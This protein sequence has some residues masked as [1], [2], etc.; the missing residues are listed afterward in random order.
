MRIIGRMDLARRASR[1]G[2]IVPPCAMQGA[3]GAVR[4][5]GHFTRGARRRLVLL[6]LAL[7]VG[8]A[9]T[10]RAAS[11]AAPAWRPPLDRPP[12]DPPLVLT[13]DFG[14]ARAN[15]FHAGLDI[16]TG[17]AVGRPVY[18]PLPGAIVR[19]R[20]SGVGYGRSL[21][22]ESD[23]G[24]LF[25]FGHLDAF[26]EPVASW[27]AAVQESTGRYEQDLWPG[28]HRFPVRSG[29]QIAWSGESGAGPPHL[30]FEIR[31]GDMAYNPLRA[32]IVMPDT[33]PPSIRAITLEPLDDG[34]RVAGGIGPRRYV[35]TRSETL[36]VRARGR[37]RVLVDARD[38]RGDGVYA[39]APWSVRLDDG[40]GFVAVRFDSASWAGD[41]PEVG[42]AYDG[43]RALGRLSRNALEMWAAPGARPRVFA[44]DAPA[45]VEAGAVTLRPG[46]PPRVLRI[47]ARD[48]AGHVTRRVLRLI[49]ERDDPTPP[50][51]EGARAGARAVH[52]RFRF[53]PL[54]GTALRVVATGA[55]H[56]AADAPGWMD[57]GDWR[58]ARYAARGWT[59]ITAPIESVT[60]TRLALEGPAAGGHASW[61]ATGPEV[62]L[63]PLREA[64][65]WRSGALTWRIGD[66]DLFGPAV[67]AEETGDS[68]RGTSELKPVSGWV[69]L[70]PADLPLRGSLDVGMAPPGAS[71][72]RGVGLYVG[73]G[74]NWSLVSA[75][76]DST[77]RAFT[78]TT[79][80]LGRFALL[81]DRLAPRVGAP[82]ALRHRRAVPYSR[83]AVESRVTEN[84]SGLDASASHFEIDGRTVP[85]EW[86]PER[87]VL[88]WRPLEPPAHGTHRA[89]VVAVDFA[90]N[91]V[92]RSAR[93]V[94]E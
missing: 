33:S 54:A 24:L 55:P 85:T 42:I 35:T 86:D 23:T 71:D 20:T 56:A 61:V 78:G 11:K 92:R 9:C 73:E 44:T 21:Y 74:S 80:R 84:G 17:G 64:G 66:E 65:V 40:G 88:R 27:V 31:R 37:V 58:E 76:F 1:G 67:V 93:F 75:T 34:A 72:L 18:A 41:M 53:E 36:S 51:P 3:D 63:I 32:G 13:S 91:R 4:R 89:V 69:G 83:W 47:E 5:P 29:Q 46:G 6:L 79:R 81:R 8:A 60:T 15:H 57:V 22:L 45:N 2:R 49:P 14:E 39:M 50:R 52:A 62:R 77:A 28:A 16:S 10:A 30:H 43:G 26:A 48:V 25:V 90:G 19:V 87:R 94:I 59:A 68:L 7:V 12:V 82:R 38:A 70:E